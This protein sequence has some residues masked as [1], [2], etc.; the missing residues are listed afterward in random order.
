MTSKQYS[1]CIA[2]ALICTDR[3]A[4][5]SDLCLSSIWGDPDGADIP[6]GRDLVAGDIWDAV[7]RSFRDILADAKISRAEFARRFASPCGRRKIGW[8]RSVSR[9]CTSA[10]RSSSSW[11]SS[12]SRSIDPKKFP[13]RRSAR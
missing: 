4:Y 6:A 13:S 3:A 11:A 1:A 8:P 10:W 2:E 5:I 12:L 9:P 7:H